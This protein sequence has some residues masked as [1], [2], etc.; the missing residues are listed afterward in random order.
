MLFRSE[1]LKQ[2][3]L[4]VKY[5]EMFDRAIEKAEKFKDKL[6]EINSLITEEMMYDYDNL[7]ILLKLI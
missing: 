7:Q 5:E 2:E 4:T 1:Q 6:G 3:Q